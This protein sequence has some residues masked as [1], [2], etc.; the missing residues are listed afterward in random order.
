MPVET[1]VTKEI[2]ILNSEATELERLDKWMDEFAVR[3][4]LPKNIHYQVN[5]ALEELVL[6]VVKH[7]RCKPPQGA[8]RVSIRLE[9]GAIEIV[10]SDNGTPFDPLRV[11]EPDLDADLADRPVGGLGIYLVRGIVDSL[12][13]ERRDGKNWLYLTKRV[14]GIEA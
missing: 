6:N 2:L 3:Q 10:L 5:V 14:R 12:R 11:P 13:Y 7:A 4:N 8:I 9:N 1:T